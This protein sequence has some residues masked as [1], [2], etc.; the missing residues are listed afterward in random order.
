MHRNKKNDILNIYQFITLHKTKNALFVQIEENT[1]FR[2]KTVREKL[3]L[4]HLM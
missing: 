1:S 3:G 2:C 4:S